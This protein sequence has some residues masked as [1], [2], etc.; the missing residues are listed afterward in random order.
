MKISKK[1]LEDTWAS[2]DPASKSPAAKSGFE[3]LMRTIDAVGF[4]EMKKQAGPKLE[5]LLAQLKA[6]ALQNPAPK[7]KGKAKR[8][9]AKRLRESMGPQPDQGAE[10]STALGLMKRFV[11][12]HGKERT[13][14]QAMALLKAVKRA[15]LLKHV[16][17]SVKPTPLQKEVKH[18]QKSLLALFDGQL[19]PGDGKTLKE[20]DFNDRIVGLFRTVLKHKGPDPGTD[21]AFAFL[22]MEGTAPPVGKAARLLKDF[23]RLLWD[24]EV[25]LSV[26]M[27]VLIARMMGSLDRYINGQSPRVEINETVLEG[28]CRRRTRSGAAPGKA[29][30][31]ER[32]RRGTRSS[33]EGKAAPSR[34]AR[35]RRPRK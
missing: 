14:K 24:H 15:V 16:R 18:I 19:D 1:I 34:P 28:P 22:R 12:M 25:Q 11:G 4:D 7:G 5:S 21:E 23:E 26:Q 17:F 32:T 30:K 6:D 9:T 33:R 31:P 29:G 13:G 10:L 35:N 3:R 2:I 27:G 8:E 20:I